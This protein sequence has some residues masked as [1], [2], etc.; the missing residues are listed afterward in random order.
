[1]T[2]VMVLVFLGVVNWQVAKSP[3][4]TVSY[5]AGYEYEAREALTNFECWRAAVDSLTGADRRQTHLAVQ[6]LGLTS[7]GF[8]DPVFPSIN[9]YPYP[10][11]YAPSLDAIPNWFRTL[12]VHEYTHLAHLT[13]TRGIP[14][15]LTRYGGTIFQPNLYSPGW[16]YEGITVYAESRLSVFEGRLNDGFYDA[17]IAAQVTAGSL[18]SIVGATNEPLAFPYGGIYAYGGEFFDFLARRYGEQRFAE[19]FQS[20]GAMTIAPVSALFPGLGI[21][22]VSKRIYGRSLPRLFDEWRKD[23]GGLAGA[24]PDPSERLTHGGWYASSLIEHRGK[25]YFVRS[26]ATKHD[27]LAVHGYCHIVE[28]NPADRS[29]RVVKRLMRSPNAPLQ[30]R[31]GSIYYTHPELRSAPNVSDRGIGTTVRLH[32]LDLDDLTDRVLFT[33]G[34]RAFCVL[35]DGTIIYAVDRPHAFGSE[36][37]RYRAGAHESLATSDWLIVELA[38]DGDRVIAAARRQDRNPDLCELRADSIVPLFTTP[39]VE[40]SIRLRSDMV[41]YSANDSGICRIHL[42]D[43]ATGETYR[44]DGTRYRLAGAIIGDTLYSLDLHGAGFDLYQRPADLVPHRIDDTEPSLPACTCAVPC[45]RGSVLDLAATLMPSIHLPFVLPGDDEWRNWRVGAVLAGTDAIRANAYAILL[46]HQPGVRTPFRTVT[47]ASLSLSPLALTAEYDRDAGYVAAASYPLW[48]S[49]GPGLTNVMLGL[50]YAASDGLARRAVTPSLGLTWRFPDLVISIKGAVPIERPALGSAITRTAYTAAFSAQL[51]GDNHGFSLGLAAFADP[52]DPEPP[53]LRLRGLAPIATA[54]GAAARLEY[55]QRLA[56]IRRGLWDPN[57][58]CEDL[59][60]AFF[61]DI[62]IDADAQW[63]RS[64]G[65]LL[66]AEMKTAFGYVPF[67]P[68]VGIAWSYQS[69]PAF[70]ISVRS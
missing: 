16:V 9:C 47:A 35:D 58:Y 29:M 12:A 60:I 19:F 3:H 26:G 28:Y 17:I 8:T 11:G 6:D 67:V 13:T 63:H 39:W 14:R 36:I 55:T 66:R 68:E 10:S 27:A 31:D 23:A 20:Y 45:E 62:G 49:V 33:A 25:L 65:C 69:G 30:A 44:L 38:A 2:P 22:R 7:N 56:R 21:D 64:W 50:T 32:R 52:E 15:L 53:E 57:I 61:S 1:M 48:Y 34:L 42:H 70:L 18:P 37:W 41:L 54:R 59:F 43:L 4:F 51:L 40:G 24:T 46:D 5:P